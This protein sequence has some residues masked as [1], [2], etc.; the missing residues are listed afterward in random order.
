MKKKG[1]VGRKEKK[2]RKE[3]GGPRKK[4]HF[5]PDGLLVWSKIVFLRRG[6]NIVQNG[7]SELLVW[8]NVVF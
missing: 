3:Q 6:K 5:G 7:I 8:F 2:P 4:H 1:G